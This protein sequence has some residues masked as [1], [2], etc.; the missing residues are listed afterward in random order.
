MIALIRDVT[1]RRKNEARFAAL[2]EAAPD[3]M[4][5]VQRDGIIAFVNHQT[6][7]LFGY[8]RDE[9]LGRPI[10]ILVPDRA[11]D[12]HSDQRAGFFTQPK[13]RPMG[14]GSDL[15]GR[16]K[17]GTE[18]PAEI[19]LSSIETEDGFLVTAAIRD[20]TERKKSQ[21]RLRAVANAARRLAPAMDLPAV[22]IA[23]LQACRDIYPD[24]THGGV[25]LRDATGGCLRWSPAW[26]SQ[27]GEVGPRM[28]DPGIGQ[29]EALSGLVHAIDKAVLPERPTELLALYRSL[30]STLRRPGGEPFQSLAAAPLH[31]PE[32]GVIGVLILGSSRREHVWEEEDVTVVE[33]LADEAALAT[34][35]ARL[36][37]LQREQAATDPLTGI[38]NR[39]A[40]ERALAESEGKQASILAIDVD[41]LKRVNDEFGHEAGDWL[42]R[43]VA[44]MLARLTRKDDVLARVGGD[45]FAVLLPGTAKRDALEVAERMRQSLYGM[46][47][48]HA[49]A[50]ISI[51][52]AA[53]II[54]GARTAAWRSADEALRA[55]KRRGGDLVVGASRREKDQAP[56]WPTELI[57]RLLEGRLPLQIAYQPIVRVADR[58]VV[59]YEALARPQG[60]AA[61]SSVDHLFKAAHR[62]HRIRDLDWLCRRRALETAT[63][64][65]PGVPVFVNVSATALLDTVHPV[66]QLLLLLS[67]VGRAPSDIVLEISERERAWDLRRL[68]LV[69]AAYREHGIRFA[70]DDVGEGHST[71]E[72]LATAMPEFI[73]LAGSLIADTGQPGARGTIEAAVAFARCAGAVVIAEGIEDAAAAVRVAELGIELG[74]G[75]WLGEPCVQPPLGSVRLLEAMPRLSGMGE[76]TKTTAGEGSPIP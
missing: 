73:K 60:I 16:R 67:W 36:Y 33:S 63:T 71:F 76:P 27:D 9:L 52:V 51:G 49:Q 8:R 11:R 7:V 5:G 20:I 55:A 15:S 62:A 44:E 26:L 21:A 32:H 28:F 29:G 41:N 42:L 64:I 61:R 10:E 69:L 13:A 39:R 75:Y 65:P 4:V 37:E 30:P 66:D 38:R 54:G 57:A 23:V 25:V 2:L 53:G 35:R 31:V 1:H 22:A 18:F 6:E 19:S 50:R 45:E 46:A 68:R 48:P 43:A 74:Q 59:G 70:L 14:A 58:L 24:I 34:E 3:A 72:V 56:D 47:L 12:S 40:F 17:D